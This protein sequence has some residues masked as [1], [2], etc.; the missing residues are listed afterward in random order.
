MVELLAADAGTRRALLRAVLRS[1]GADYALVAST[2]RVD[3]TPAVRLRSFGPLVTWRQLSDLPQPDLAS[4]RL[5]VG[6]LEL[7]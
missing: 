2:A 4:V 3:P 7:F 5:E 6:D 1:T